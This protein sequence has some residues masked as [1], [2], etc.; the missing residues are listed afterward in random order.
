VTDGNDPS[1]A[2]SQEMAAWLIAFGPFVILLV[3]MVFQ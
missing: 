1:F 2:V 3:G